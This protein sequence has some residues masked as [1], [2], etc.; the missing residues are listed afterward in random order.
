MK[1]KKIASLMLAGVMAI[2]MLAGCSNGS[3]TDEDKTETNDLTSAVVAALNEGSEVNYV[4]SDDLA[5]AVNAVKTKFGTENYL[6][7]ITLENLAKVAG[8]VYTQQNFTNAKNTIDQGCSATD[9][10]I[11]AAVKTATA[12]Y[13]ATYFWEVD[14]AEGVS[15]PEVAA[16]L[17]VNEIKNFKD[18]GKVAST[19]R[20]EYA[21]GTTARVN[22]TYGDTKVSVYSDLDEG[23]PVYYVT[24]TI[25][26][27]GSEAKL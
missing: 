18:A 2:S 7:N 20:Y 1:L 9:E 10:Q 21:D 8:D 24:C 19:N 23:K 25:T 6:A 26:R 11:K 22:F 14:K 4:A 27:T 3:N 13:T 17:I 12:A 5:K 16:K 15:D